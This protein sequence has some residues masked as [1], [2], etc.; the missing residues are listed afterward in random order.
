[1]IKK[2]L[3]YHFI[4]KWLVFNWFTMIKNDFKI[5]LYLNNLFLIDLEWFFFKNVM[6]GWFAMLQNAGK[7]PLGP[8]YYSLNS[9]NSVASLNGLNTLNVGVNSGNR[10]GFSPSPVPGPRPLSSSTSATGSTS[11]QVHCIIAQENNQHYA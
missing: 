3:L 8:G 7:P 10:Q 2:L 4:L 9:M 1:M 6:L 5:I 11:Q